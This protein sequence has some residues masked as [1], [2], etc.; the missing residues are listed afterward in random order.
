MTWRPGR[1]DGV[2]FLVAVLAAWG[3]QIAHLEPEQHA[4]TVAVLPVLAAR[5]HP[6]GALLLSCVLIFAY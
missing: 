5:R 4:A 6:A 1:V 2:L 3:A